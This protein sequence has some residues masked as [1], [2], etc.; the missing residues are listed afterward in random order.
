MGAM[1]SARQRP[2]DLGPPERGEARSSLTQPA[3]SE[4]YTGAVPALGEAAWTK[5]SSGSPCLG[6]EEEGLKSCPCSTH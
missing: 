1:T 4:C 6:G 2:G 5:S 3:S